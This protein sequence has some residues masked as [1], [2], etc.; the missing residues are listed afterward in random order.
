[1]S[2]SLAGCGA[3]VLELLAV[4]IGHASSSVTGTPKA[5]ASFEKSGRRPVAP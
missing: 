3:G 4:E 2:P 5:F 1:M